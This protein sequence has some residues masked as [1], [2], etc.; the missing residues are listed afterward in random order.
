VD[1]T[2]I[3]LHMGLYMSKQTSLI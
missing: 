3:N 2:A 1:D